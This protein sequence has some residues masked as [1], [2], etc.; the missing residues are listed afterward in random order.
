[1][2]AGERCRVHRGW[3][4]TP[5]WQG[6]ARRAGTTPR[7][8][9]LSPPGSRLRARTRS[10]R[11]P[12]QSRAGAIPRPQRRTRR[13]RTRWLAKRWRSGRRASGGL[14]RRGSQVAGHLLGN[15]LMR[16]TAEYL[17]QAWR[18]PRS[19]G[20]RK[21]P[22]LRAPKTCQRI[23]DP[24]VRDAPVLHRVNQRLECCRLHVGLA[25]AHEQRI[26]AGH[27]GLYRRLG[28]FVRLRDRLHLE[29]VAQNDAAI[30]ELVA[31][32][33]LNDPGRERG[34]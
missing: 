4:S 19:D 24:L 8:V 27:N 29:I 25:A 12:G 3:P 2:A 30:A 9:R 33:G 21:K 6:P 26:A 1:M 13:A 10:R 17:L 34:G 7:A 18:P 23:F 22:L 14:G 15:P 20:R 16:V 5:E 32:D 31:Q 11:T 28:N